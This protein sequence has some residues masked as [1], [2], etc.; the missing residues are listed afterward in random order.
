MTPA[1]ERVLATFAKSVPMCQRVPGP[2]QRNPSAVDFGNSTWKT[3]LRLL[4]AADKGRL[5]F[6]RLYIDNYK[7]FVNFTL[8][9]RE[10]TLLTGYNG[11]GKTS[12]LDVMFALRELLSGGAKVSDPM[13]FPASSKTAWQTNDIQKIELHAE[14][15]GNELCYCLEVDHDEKQNLVR[16]SHESLSDGQGQPLFEFAMGQVKLFR[17]DHSEGPTYHADWLESAMA[18]VPSRPDNE[19]LSKFLDAIRNIVVC[20]LY[21]VNFEPETTR[22][23][24]MLDRDAGN[25]SSWF[26]HAQL[27]NP[28][29]VEELKREVAEVIDGLDQIRLQKTGLNRRALMIGF[30]GAGKRYE[31]PFDEISDGQRALIALHALI[32]LSSGL[33]YTLFLDEPENY[34]AISEIQP[35]LTEL[36]DHCGDSIPQAVICTHHPEVVDLLG[37]EHGL[38]LLRERSGATRI[39]ELSKLSLDAED[40]LRLSELLARG[41]T[42]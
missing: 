37:P 22:P 38:C 20:G 30:D 39:K 9:L 12:V 34:V 21:P 36:V 2:W 8:D 16:I 33:G 4:N 32:H 40:G 26:Q 6:K 18:R 19:R 24:V 28:G 29:H 42:E 10:L 35:W 3:V 41:W 1:K 25:F 14:F 11:T 5:M 31:L 17:D 15:D 13:M 23:E 7:C 27:E